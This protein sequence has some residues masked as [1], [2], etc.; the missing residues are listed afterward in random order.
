[1]AARK[2]ARASATTGQV[3]DALG[4]SER[5]VRQ[6]AER[7]VI[8][9]RGRGGWDL[10]ACREKYQ[11][12]TRAVAAGRA[13]AGEPLPTGAPG[14]SGQQSLAYEQARLA[15]E[16]ADA[17][18]MA[19]AEARRE[20]VRVEAVREAVVAAWARVRARLL[21]IPSK[22]APVL[23]GIETVP[24]MQAALTD[25]MRDALD[26]L[27]STRSLPV[28][29][30]SVHDPADLVGGLEAPAEAHG[31]RVGRS[32]AVSKPRGKRRARAMED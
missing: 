24:A 25:L 7:G 13:R 5:Y 9:R 15:K 30:G 26:E 3:A 28:G 10:E 14:A 27:A 32:R 31:Q 12:H 18:A 11:E 29:L 6:L 22:G 17:Q 20:L 1:M 19:N 23:V 2:S 8:P 21:A 4:V 16:K